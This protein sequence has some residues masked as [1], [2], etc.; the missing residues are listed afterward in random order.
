MLI[1][2]FFRVIPLVMVAVF[3]LGVVVV[4]GPVDRAREMA[5]LQSHQLAWAD[6]LVKCPKPWGNVPISGCTLGNTPINPR[7]AH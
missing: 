6:G 7:L 3:A 1:R 5:R 4:D 2:V